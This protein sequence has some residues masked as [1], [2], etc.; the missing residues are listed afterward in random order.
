MANVTPEPATVSDT[1]V[2][3]AATWKTERPDHNAIIMDTVRADTTYEH[4]ISTRQSVLVEYYYS[5]F[6]LDSDVVYIIVNVTANVETGFVHSVNITFNENYENSGVELFQIQHWSD[7]WSLF[8]HIAN[9]SIV[10][11]G[12]F[13]SLSLPM[14]T[15]GVKA[16]VA[17][18]SLNQSMSVH[19]DGIAGWFLMSPQWRTHY[20]QIMTE[21]IYYDGTAFRRVLQPFDLEIGPDDNNDWETAAEIHEGNYTGL[22]LC[23]SDSVDFYKIQVSQGQRIRINVTGL[24]Y[25]VLRF[26][27]FLYDANEEPVLVSSEPDTHHEIEFT[28]GY[29]GYLYIKIQQVQFWGYYQVEVSV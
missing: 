23:E 1:V 28:S 4:G 20:M 9:L 14:G 8:C 21:I 26:A 25:P 29:T 19:I 17:A 10:G 24:D 2:L 27:V 7:P 5:N 18:E 13:T 6:L 12:D 11:Y 16:F 22:Y 3:N 15:K